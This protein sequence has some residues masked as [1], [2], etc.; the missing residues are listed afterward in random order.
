[1]LVSENKIDDSFLQGQFV[2]EVF[3]APC[4]L[5]HNCFGGGIMLFVREH[6]P[7]N[8]LAIEEEPIESYYA[9]LSLH[10]SKWLVICF[11]I[12]LKTA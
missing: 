10:K 6:I 3:K 2:I 7:P 9:E 11:L 12:H 1:M 8:L 4:T 5:N